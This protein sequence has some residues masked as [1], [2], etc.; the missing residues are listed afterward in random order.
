MEKIELEEAKRIL[1]EDLDEV[2]RFCIENGLRYYLSGG[3]L[4]GAVRHKGFIPWDDDVDIMMPRPDYEKFIELYKDNDKF[5][6]YSTERN[7]EYL[8]TYPKLCKNKT[9]LNEK[10]GS[11][12]LQLGIYVDIFPI[13]GL[14]DDM[15]KAKKVLKKIRI[16]QIFNLGLLVDKNRDYVSFV[17]N[18]EVGICY[19]IAKLIGGH[20]FLYKRITKIAT[21]YNYEDSILVGTFIDFMDGNRIFNKEIFAKAVKLPF[22]EKEYCV[23]V[24]YDE[25]LT[26]YFGDYM[27]LPPEEDREVHGYD[28]YHIGD[29]E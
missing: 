1:I 25:F 27:K 22:G 19:V 12:G 3:T 8:Y 5:S 16:P 29:K 17:K 21:K 9:I 7:S 26:L 23:P 28:A 18:L 20:K 6:L 2:D 24:G 14:G 15:S 11:A 10:G 4:L 13:D